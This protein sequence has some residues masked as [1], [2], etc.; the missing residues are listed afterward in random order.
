MNRFALKLK[1]RQNLYKHK[2]DTSSS[3]ERRSILNRNVSRLRRD[4]LLTRKRNISLGTNMNTC[5]NSTVDHYGNILENEIQELIK[6]VSDDDN[7]EKM[8]ALSTLKVYSYGNKFHIDVLLRNNIANM[9]FGIVSQKQKYPNIQIE[10]LHLIANLSCGTFEQTE[11]LIRT[12]IMQ[13]LI[14]YLTCDE[15][16][17]LEMALLT[18]GNLL[19]DSDDLKDEFLT[20]NFCMNLINIYGLN[21]PT[22]I[23][24]VTTWVLATLC[25][26]S[27]CRKLET[28]SPLIEVLTGLLTERNRHLIRSACSGLASLCDKKSLFS[29]FCQFNTLERLLNLLNNNQISNKDYKTKQIALFA[30]SQLIKNSSRNSLIQELFS[31]FQIIGIL[32]HLF[33]NSSN[34]KPFVSDLLLVLR[35][36]SRAGSVIIQQIL[37]CQILKKIFQLY[38][39]EQEQEQEQEQKSVSN[40]NFNKELKYELSWMLYHVFLNSKNDQYLSICKQGAIQILCD[41]MLFENDLSIIRPT[42]RT[43]NSLIEF[44][45]LAI[46]D[47]F[48]EHGILKIIEKLTQHNNPKISQIS[49]NIID[50]VFLT[51]SRMYECDLENDN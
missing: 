36:A 43:I 16:E 51:H 13:Y 19:Q 10:A 41:H 5:L 17:Y 21:Y 20:N 25:Q 38:K 15:E 24:K 31:E 11:P 29:Y 47:H 46:V 40:F 33:D 49:N 28:Y 23:Y 30:I 8:F 32:N 39:Q 7:D 42:L 26:G 6:S 1:R 35:R 27:L 37:S 44:E 12:G 22:Q 18:I 48:D 4:Q 3:R 34:P 2:K 14:N 50:N 45:N 9:L